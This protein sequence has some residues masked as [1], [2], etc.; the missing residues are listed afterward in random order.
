M[1]RVWCH[2]RRYFSFGSGKTSGFGVCLVWEVLTF[3]FVG[4]SC[5]GIP[6]TENCKLRRIFTLNA[7]VMFPRFDR[8]IGA[9]CSTGSAGQGYQPWY[10]G[11]LF[12]I[13][14]WF[15]KEWF[16]C[17]LQT[18]CHVNMMLL[19]TSDFSTTH[20][21]TFQIRWLIL[22][23]ILFLDLFSKIHTGKINGTSGCVRRTFF[24]FS[25]CSK[26]ARTGR[27]VFWIA[28]LANGQPCVGFPLWNNVFFIFVIEQNLMRKH[29]RSH[30]IW[31]LRFCKIVVFFFYTRAKQNG[32][33]DKC[34]STTGHVQ[35]PCA[36]SSMERDYL[37]RNARIACGRSNCFWLCQRTKSL[38]M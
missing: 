33:L 15:G 21:P 7:P 22:I 32:G 14:K 8:T 28:L 18:M 4:L 26:K 3:G 36:N 24:F 13:S 23:L 37:V 11:T 19:R 38:Y 34:S 9:R 2:W 6:M 25:L 5:Q 16:W 17:L 29:L 27:K 1:L 35:L 12:F 30:K 20:W 31:R 10:V